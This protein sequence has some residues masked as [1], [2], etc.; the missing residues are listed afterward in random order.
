MVVGVHGGAKQF[1]SWQPGG[2][3]NEKEGARDKI[4]LS[5]TCPSNLLLLT[6]SHLVLFFFSFLV[7]LGFE[8]R[9]VC[10]LGRYHTIGATLPAL[11]CVE[12]FPDRVS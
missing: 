3:K 10:L 9:V 8:V 4:Y 7:I 1:P 2:R 6:R 5:K 11:F 12:Y